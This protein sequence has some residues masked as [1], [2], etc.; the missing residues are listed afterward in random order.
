MEKESRLEV[1]V[2]L[3]NSSYTGPINIGN[4]DEYSI[5]D[6]AEIIR[7]KINP[8]LKIIHKPL[9]SDDP[10][11]RK[12]NISLAKEYLDWEP[13]ISFNNGI[14]KTINYF[15]HKILK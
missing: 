14:D 7:S 4:P 12:P 15:H 10:N 3:M 11:R 13:K 1:F 8:K 5:L 2:L 9:P 6:I